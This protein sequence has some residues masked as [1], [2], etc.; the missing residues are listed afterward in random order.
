[1]AEIPAG[2]ATLGILPARRSAAFGWDNEYEATVRDVPAFAI[3]RYKVTN[4][5]YLEFVEAGGYRDRGLW[6]PPTWDWKEIMESSIPLFWSRA[7]G[8]LAFSRHVPGTPFA[9]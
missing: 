9:A 1:M 8:G 7:G 6:I 2:R 4:A 5:Q 3:D